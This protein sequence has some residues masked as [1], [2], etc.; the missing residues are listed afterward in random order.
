VNLTETPSA[1]TPGRATPAGRPGRVRRACP[2]GR[3][4][5]FTL[6]EVLA[7]CAL[8]GIVAGIAVPSYRD[9]QTRGR[10]ADAVAALSQLQAAEE[11]YRANNGL[12]SA[13]FG[14][15][16]VAATSPEGWYALR[17]TLDGGDHYHAS[18]NAVAGKAQA[19][20]A[21]CPQ[22]VLDVAVGFAEIGP[23]RRCWNR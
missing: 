13:D 2:A 17:I 7:T 18:A 21:A 19:G 15:L 8:V 3:C 9:Q 10:R 6:V 22:L 23:D 1:P 12:Y 14:A 5:G 11:R 4:R 16:Q 20:D